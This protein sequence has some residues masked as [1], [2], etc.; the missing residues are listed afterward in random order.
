MKK[1]DY[2]NVSL[3]NECI[4]Y[5]FKF[6]L[7]LQIYYLEWGKSFSN[8]YIIMLFKLYLNIM[9]LLEHNRNYTLSNRLPNNSLKLLLDY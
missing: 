1:F 2:L 5:S 4:S 6:V 3:F 9:Q 8:E 7:H